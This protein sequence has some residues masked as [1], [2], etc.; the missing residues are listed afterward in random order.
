[1]AFRTLSRFGK[2]GSKWAMGTITASV[3]AAAI[4]SS[5]YPTPIVIDETKPIR[6]SK[7]RVSSTCP[8][9]PS[10]KNNQTTLDTL[11]TRSNQKRPEKKLKSVV[12]PG[13]EPYAPTVTTTHNHAE[14]ELLD[15]IWDESQYAHKYPVI[16]LSEVRQHYSPDVGDG[17]VW[18][19]FKGGVYDV[20]SF[21]NHHPG[22]FGDDI[23][24]L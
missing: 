16:S 18:V 1:M 21:L 9:S 22:L 20:T 12:E 19:T 15:Q 17:S 7:A 14:K 6:S 8:T 10:M 5:S 3:A 2:H 4:V 13:I 11:S 24:T 23:F